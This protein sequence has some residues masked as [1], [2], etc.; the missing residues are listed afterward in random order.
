[1]IRFR[2]PSSDTQ[3]YCSRRRQRG[4]SLIEVLVALVVT[5]MG[6]MGLASLQ[7]LAL[8]TQHNAFLR[9][10]ATQLNH[11]I[12]ERMRGNTNA[13]LAGAYDIAYDT[14]PGAGAAIA[15]ADKREWR[16]RISAVLPEGRGSIQ[17][18]PAT[19]TATVSVRWN[20][21]RGDKGK[22]NTADGTG[23]P[24]LLEFSESTRL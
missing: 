24:V 10:Q 18:N 16:Q 9:G 15:D 4:F 23:E 6:L 1:M 14:A 3:P 13:A 8:R 2:K 19:R 17:V 7:L 22:E 5:T 12:I 21:A 11:D 20:D